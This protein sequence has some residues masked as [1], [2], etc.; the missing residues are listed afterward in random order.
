MVVK[1]RIVKSK[2]KSQKKVQQRRSRKKSSRRVSKRRSRKRVSKKKS[3]RRSLK[4]RRSRTKSQKKLIVRRKNSR[5]RK[6]SNKKQRGGSSG[7]PPS[8]RNPTFKGFFCPTPAGSGVSASAVRDASLPASSPSRQENYREW[9]ESFMR[10]TEGVDASLFTKKQKKD[11]NNEMQQIQTDLNDIYGLELTELSDTCRP[12]GTE[13]LDK[14]G[15][16]LPEVARSAGAAADVVPPSVDRTAAIQRGAAIAIALLKK[17]GVGAS[18]CI[19]GFIFPR[20]GAAGLL[21]NRMF[22]KIKDKILNSMFLLTAMLRVVLHNVKTVGRAKIADA[23]EAD[24]SHKPAEF[25]L[26]KKL[27]HVIVRYPSGKINWDASRNKINE[28]SHLKKKT[29]FDNVM[30]NPGM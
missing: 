10:T 16:D 2:K 14:M 30:A 28:L 6:G 20:V 13:E 7:G 1:K 23:I 19:F 8:R 17:H 21:M 18:V 12:I 4:V 24:F 3:K 15:F 22:P 11:V 25:L 9:A 29:L 27:D 5:R 26:L